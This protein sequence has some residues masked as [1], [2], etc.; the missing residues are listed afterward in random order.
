MNCETVQRLLDEIPLSLWPE[1]QNTSVQEHC[2]SCNGCMQKLEEEKLMFA[3]FDAMLLAEPSNMA[4]DFSQQAE[5]EKSQ[6]LTRRNRSFGGAFISGISL[7]VLLLGLVDQIFLQGG[8]SFDHF[9]GPRSWNIA[10]Y[11]IINSPSLVATLILAA[12]VYCF[13]SNNTTTISR[14][15]ASGTRSESG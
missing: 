4:I 1:L 2:H 11:Q 8:L 12:L 9:M 7:A 10:F 13:S 14:H 6:A 15:S 3:E 5:I